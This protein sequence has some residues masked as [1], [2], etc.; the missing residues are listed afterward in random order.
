MNF[1]E[2]LEEYKKLQLRYPA[3]PANILQSENS[4]AGNYLYRCKDIF[5]GF[6]LVECEDSVY[7]ADSFKSKSCVD[8]D[9]VIT[10]ENCY[11][12]FDIVSVSNS[13]FIWGSD[14]IYDSMFCWDC[15]D[16]HDLFGCM[17]LKHKEFCIFNK[18][19]SQEEYKIKKAELMKKVPEENIE[20]MKKLAMKFPVTTTRVFNSVNSDYGNHVTNSKNM[21]MCFD[22]NAGE[23]CGYM[24]DTHY[25]KNCYDLTQCAHSEFCYECSDSARLNNCCYMEFCSDIYDSAFCYNCTKSNHLF[26]CVDLENQE[27]CILNKKYPKEEYEKTVKEMIESYREQFK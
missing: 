27:Y 14:R 21:Y 5:F 20:E 23:N 4:D 2:F 16:S 3:R 9:Y 10:S 18:Q 11:D 12:C 1:Q 8:G 13:A 25:C 7:L 6:D 17:H 19:H 22:C 24:Y 15:Y 26:G